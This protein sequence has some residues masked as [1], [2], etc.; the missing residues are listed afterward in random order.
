MPRLVIAGAGAA[1]LMAAGIALSNGISVTLVE[2]MPTPGRK[3]AITGKGRCNVTNAC[4]EDVF[5]NNIRNNPKFLYSAVYNFP[6]HRLMRFFEEELCVPLK[7]ERGRRVFPKSDNAE[8]I[9]NAL[10]EYAQ[11]ADWVHG[12]AK[13]LLVNNGRAAGLVLQDGRHIQGDAVLLATGGLSYPTTGS[14]GIGYNIA[15][16]A[17]HNI[18]PCSPSLVALVEKGGVCK[19]CA[20]LSL[21][22]VKLTLLC[23]KK[24]VFCEQG[25]MLFTHFGISGPLTL[26]ASAYV[27]DAQKHS[28]T[29]CIDLKPALRGEQLD[30][31]LQKDFTEG[32][33]RTA[34]HALDKLLPQSMRGVMLQLWGVDE[35]RKINQITR[36]ERKTLI[37]LLK[38]FRIP[39][40]GKG[41]LEHAVITSGGVNVKEV[42]PKTMQSRILPGLYFA[43]EILD[44]DGYTG[45]YNLHIAWC[46]AYAAANAI[47]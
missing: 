36:D 23:G 31:R 5:L 27:G 47:V 18:V 28:Y 14:T 20:G 46:T 35:D 41:S 3:L 13:K 4:S 30:L 7:T 10:I 22:N 24:P 26:S 11:G 6:P 12:S 39:I 44:V 15:K 29:V 25:E 8:E 45:G 33:N 43:G 38:D 17:G 40:A 16:K 9:V 19:R 34:A 21:R 1:G 2:H 42:D 32:A 37:A